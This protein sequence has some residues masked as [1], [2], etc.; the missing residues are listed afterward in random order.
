VPLSLKVTFVCSISS[1]K[2]SAQE[3]FTFLFWVSFCEPERDW[4]QTLNSCVQSYVDTKHRVTWTTTDQQR[5]ERNRTLSTTNCF[6]RV[7]TLFL[8]IHEHIKQGVSKRALQR[9]S[10]CYCVMSVTK[11]FNQ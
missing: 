1:L 2:H 4:K 7:G 3:T 10:K 11:S 8:R 5:S 6:C 9:Y